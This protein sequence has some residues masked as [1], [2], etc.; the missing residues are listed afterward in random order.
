MGRK[1]KLREDC[2]EKGRKSESEFMRSTE[3]TERSRKIGVG[4]R[5]T[6]K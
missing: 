2:E 1:E 5:M 3:T 6:R 4:R